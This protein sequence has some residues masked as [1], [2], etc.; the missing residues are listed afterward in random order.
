MAMV[1]TSRGSKNN[2]KMS[3]GLSAGP[4]IVFPSAYGSTS[5][6][7]ARIGGR[8]GGVNNDGD[9]PAILFCLDRVLERVPNFILGSYHLVLSITY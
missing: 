7:A 8:P 1:N 5:C 3:T 9:L 6:S 2:D 4:R